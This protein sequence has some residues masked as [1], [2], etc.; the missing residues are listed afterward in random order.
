MKAKNLS[1]A[2]D[3]VNQTPFGLTS[4]IETLDKREKEQWLDQIE[5]GNLYINRETTGAIVLRQPFGGYKQSAFGLGIK[6]GG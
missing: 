1:H 4:A 6:A 2:I 5:A 3:I